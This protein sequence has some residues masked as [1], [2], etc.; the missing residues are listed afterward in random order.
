[1]RKKWYTAAFGGIL[2]ALL[3]EISRYYGGRNSDSGDRSL[4]AVALKSDSVKVVREFYRAAR[5]R[6][7]AALLKVLH[8][9]F[10]G[11]LA[12]GMPGG[13]GG[14]HS[15][16]TAMMRDAWGS[17]FH[18]FDVTAHPERWYEAAD[19]TII[20]TGRY[21][22][23]ANS[24]GRSFEAEFVHLWTVADGLLTGVHQCSDTQSW[25]DALHAR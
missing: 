12:P 7:D 2:T 24:S 9:E 6:D 3:I 19:G 1:M 4:D 21:V 8:P 5:T 10:V 16:R 20:V 25:N 14:I 15:G 17:L 18:L 22:G 23:T 11:S 13:A